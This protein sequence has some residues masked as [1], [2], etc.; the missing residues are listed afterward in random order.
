MSISYDPNKNKTN[1]QLR[2]L[3]FERVSELDWDNAWIFED[4]RNEYN[5]TR[6]IA[7]SML[8]KRL[9]FVCFTETKGGIRIISFRKAN[10]REV[11]RYEQETINR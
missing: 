2:N 3:D 7:Y 11:K 5:E 4:E 10:S 8:D 9:H 6:F 1:I